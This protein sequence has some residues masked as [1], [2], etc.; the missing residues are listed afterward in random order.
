MD[1]ALLA[2]FD[3]YKTNKENK[4]KMILAIWLACV[5]PGVTAQ[6]KT[7][8]VTKVKKGEEPKVVLDAIKTDFPDFIA[9]DLSFL[10]AKLYGEEWNVNFKG[11][12]HRKWNRPGVL[13]LQF[14]RSI[15]SGVIP[16]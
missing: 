7:L 1:H 16:G 11:Y 2:K 5:A 4:K 8:T 15:L 9:K 10:P 3:N 6:Q 12:S 14:I 13:M